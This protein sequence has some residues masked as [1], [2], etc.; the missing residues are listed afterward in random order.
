MLYELSRSG[1][2]LRGCTAS[3]LRAS[4]D[5]GTWPSPSTTNHTLDPKPTGLEILKPITSLRVSRLA[6]NPELYVGFR[7]ERLVPMT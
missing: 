7:V 4:G 1:S 3:H 5:S 2:G 6:S